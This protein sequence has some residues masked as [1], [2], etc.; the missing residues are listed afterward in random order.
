MSTNTD[1]FPG[2]TSHHLPTPDG[3]TIFV[4]TSNSKSATSKPPLLLLHGYPQTHIEFHK[5]APLLTPHFTLILPDLRGYGASSPAPHSTN[6]SGYTKRL[7]A[8]DCVSVM[9]QLGYTK[10]AVAGH[11]RGARVAY[12]LAFDHPSR[13]SSVVVMD[14]VP[15]AEMFRGFGDVGR[16][17]KGWHWLFLAQAEPFPETMIGAGDGGRVYLE[18]AMGS[19]TGDGTLGVFTEDMMGRYREAYCVEERIHSTC[20]DYRA[21]AAFDRVYDEEELAAGRKIEVPVL[22]VWG[23]SGLFAGEMMKKKQKKGEGEGP[24][25]VWQR[26]CVDVRGKGLNCGHFVPEEDPEG[27]A[28]EILRF[29]L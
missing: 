3:T 29:L 2:F 13:V 19:W 25:E 20:E 23:E 18:Y 21:A 7:M 24:V 16:G 6:G 26:Y 22:A 9:S 27:L 4:R 1:L 11:D 12:R 15:T 17:L 14:I 10:F 28:E 5:L 8:Q